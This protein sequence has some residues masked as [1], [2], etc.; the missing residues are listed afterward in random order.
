[1]DLMFLNAGFVSIYIN[2]YAGAK[3]LNT[4]INSLP[5]ALAQTIYASGFECAFSF[6]F[7]SEK[8]HIVSL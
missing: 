2:I 8:L 1:M 3:N 6:S 5:A 4:N 7:L